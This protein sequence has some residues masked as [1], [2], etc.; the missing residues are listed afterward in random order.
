MILVDTSVWIDHFNG[1]DTVQVRL[2]DA[3]LGH[4]VLLLGDLVLAELLHS[5]RDFDQM[6]AAL[7]LRIV[8]AH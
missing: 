4:E 7:G 8:Q 1:R 6:S 2:L 5:D 3:L